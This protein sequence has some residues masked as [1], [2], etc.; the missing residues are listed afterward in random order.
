MAA[1]VKVYSVDVPVPSFDYKD[2]ATMIANDEKYE[3]DVEAKIRELGYNTPFTGKMIK[4]GA[5]DGYAVYM[6]ASLRPLVLIHLEYGDAWQFQYVHLLT[7]NEVMKQLE[8]EAAMKKL[9]ARA[10]K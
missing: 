6:I 3:K 1:K 10:R 2:H 4:F 7:A 5:G 8:H 9:F